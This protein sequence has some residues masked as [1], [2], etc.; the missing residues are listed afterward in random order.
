MKSISYNVGIVVV[1]RV[2][3]GL[4][5]LFTVGIITRS[6]GPDGYGSYNTIVAFVF[7]F[8][9]LADGGL[10][11][12]LLKEI[13]RDDRNEKRLVNNLFTY[14]LILTVFFIVIGNIVAYFLNYSGEIRLGIALASLF[15]VGSSLVQILNPV[16]QKRMAMFQLTLSDVI[17]RAIQL[18]LLLLLIQQGSH[19]ISFIL[20]MVASELVRFAMVMR[21]ANRFNHIQLTFDQKIFR[22]TLDSALPIAVSLIFILLYFKLDTILLSLMKPAYDVGVYSVAYK[23]LETIL[24]LPAVFIGLI[25]PHLSKSFANAPSLFLK[26]FQNSFDII[27]IFA[28]PCGLI[29]AFFAKPIIEII[30]GTGFVG[31]PA[32]L[33][34]LSI[35]IVVIFFGTLY[36]NMILVLNLQRKSLFV[37]LF[38]LLFNM[39]F[40]IIFIPRYSY[41]AAAFVTVATEIFVTFGMAYLVYRSLR[42]LPQFTIFIKSVI[43]TLLLA[44]VFYV[45]RDRFFLALCTAPLYFVFLFA[46]RAYSLSDIRSFL[47]FRGNL[48]EAELSARA[49]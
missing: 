24:F 7:L 40:N 5:S 8:M 36:S 20:I 26:L 9:S 31:A 37:Y 17:A 21:Y 48:T 38:A 34:I 10:Y 1:G 39:T 41:Y 32:V 46:L 33:V 45:M 28:L 15:A 18:G 43:A 27:T 47:L 23:I 3:V 22:E 42:R 44:C 14:R 25:T 11:S 13:S 2:I 6:L 29:L 16:F 49:E 19:L 30:A 4:V 12:V 35:A